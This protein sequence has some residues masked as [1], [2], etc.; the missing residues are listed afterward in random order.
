MLYWIAVTLAEAISDANTDG[1]NSLIYFNIPDDSSTIELGQNL[2]NINQAVKWAI[3]GSAFK[4]GLTIN[5]GSLPNSNRF[6]Y[7]TSHDIDIN[8]NKIIF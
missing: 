8:L 6:L 2:S 5:M 1:N 3:D 4:D 7:F